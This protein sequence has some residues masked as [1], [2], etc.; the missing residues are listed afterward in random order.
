MV[1]WHL[2][3]LDATTISEIFICFHLIKP[4]V[5]QMTLVVAN[6]S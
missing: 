6:A 3:A 1:G 5:M 2:A 4:K